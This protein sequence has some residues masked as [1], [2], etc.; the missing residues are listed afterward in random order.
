MS[1]CELDRSPRLGPHAGM[2]FPVLPA[3]VAL[4]LI[5]A[6]AGAAETEAARVVTAQ[7]LLGSWSEDCSKEPD[8]ENG[9]EII[10]IDPDG[11]ARTVEEHIEWSS[12]YRITAAR[13]IDARDTWMRLEHNDDGEIY[14]V[15]YRL[16][17]NRQRTWRSTDAQGKVL[18]DNGLFTS[19]GSENGWYM[20]CG[21]LL[22]TTP[23]EKQE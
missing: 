10:S 15:V 8:L 3:A 21:G 22:P 4:V 5:A 20:R 23:R 6:P 2:R 17:D 13:R 1:G 14:E 9:W 7:G 11:E 12:A 18:V 19:D 16:E